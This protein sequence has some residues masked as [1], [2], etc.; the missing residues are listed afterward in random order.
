MPLPKKAAKAASKASLRKHT[1]TRKATVSQRSIDAAVAKAMSKGRMSGSHQPEQSFGE[2]AGAFLGG[3]AQ[4]AIKALTGFGEYKAGEFPIVKNAVLEAG[5]PPKVW[6]G[7]KDNIVRHREYIQDIYSGV[8]GSTGNAA[9][10]PFKVDSFSINPAVVRTFPWLSNIAARYEQWEIE[11]M[12]F[13]YK[14]MFSDAAV[15]VGGSLG[16]VIMAT[17][18]NA[19]LPPFASKIVMENYEYAQSDKPSRSMIHPIECSGHLSPLKELW[20]RAPGQIIS[21]QDIKTYDFGNFQIASQGIPVTGQAAPL[22]ELWVTYQIR[23]IKPKIFT[24]LD[25]GFAYLWAAEQ[26]VPSGGQ[27][28]F[29]PSSFATPS[30]TVNNLGVTVASDTSLKIPCYADERTYM[31][32]IA[33]EDPVPGTTQGAALG[34]FTNTAPTVTNGSTVNVSNFRGTQVSGSVITSGSWFVSYVKTAAL[35]PGVL[36]CTVTYAAP[37]AASFNVIREIVVNAVPAFG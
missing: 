20:V 19:A 25:S 2:K 13:E 23:L 11:G 32:A 36:D 1:T 24:Y 30:L 5:D 17:E 21:G 16:T 15:Q 10:S 34:I 6:N 9:P 12:L 37:L 28:F 33:V 22:G 7:G 3:V 31:I 4:K 27:V 35:A 18:Y 8:A 14:S 29:N 26:T